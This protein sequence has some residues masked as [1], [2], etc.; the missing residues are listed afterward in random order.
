[1]ESEY[2]VSTSAQKKKHSQ[3]T[4]INDVGKQWKLA[5]TGYKKMNLCYTFLKT[6]TTPKNTVIRLK[7]PLTVNAATACMPLH[8]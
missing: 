3:N 2:F 6:W 4:D 5:Q 8:G 1:M 7:H